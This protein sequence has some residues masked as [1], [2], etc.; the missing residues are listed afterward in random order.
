MKGV[1]MIV[2]MTVESHDILFPNPPDGHEKK[3]LSKYRRWF[4]DVG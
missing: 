3:I 4:C 1:G 2:E